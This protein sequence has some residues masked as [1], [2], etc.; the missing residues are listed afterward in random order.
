M[1]I[2]NKKILNNYQKNYILIEIKTSYKKYSEDF[3]SLDLVSKEYNHEIFFLPTD[4]YMFETFD[5]DDNN[6][7]LDNKYYI[8]CKSDEEAIIDFSS[9][10]DDI[11]KF[12][13]I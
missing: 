2:I 12:I 10:F 9:G 6:T 8:N 4:Q 3:F 5:L 13:F 11:L 1:L 7:F